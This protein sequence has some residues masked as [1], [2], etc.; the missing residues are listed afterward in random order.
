MSQDNKTCEVTYWGI[1]YTG[2]IV[3]PEVA[4][5]NN[6]KYAVVSI[7]E[8][9]FYN[10]ADLTSAVI[11]S[12]VTSIG[13]NAFAYCNNLTS[14]TVG[15]G[16]TSIGE[17]AFGNCEKLEAVYITDLAA[18]C[19]IDFGV[20]YEE[21]A[22]PLFNAHNLYL[23]GELVTSL[24]IPDGV[25]NINDYAFCYCTSITSVATSNS[26][27]N[28]GMYA[29]YDCTNL[30]SIDI[31]NSVTSI[32]RAAFAECEKLSSVT[33]G[34]GVRD[35]GSGAFSQCENLKAVYITDIEAWCKIN[36]NSETSNPIPYAH[37]LYINGQLATSITIPETITSIN[38]YAFFWCSLTSIDIPNSVTSIGKYAFD[39]CENLSSIVIPNSVTNIGYGA[40]SKCTNLTSIVIP[41]SLTSISERAFNE[42]KSL[43]TVVIPNGV[44]SIGEYAFA[45]CHGL[46]S[47]EIPSSITTIG[48]AAF[49]GCTSLTTVNIHDLKAWCNIDFSWSFGNAYN[50]YLNGELVEELTIPESITEIKVSTFYY[51][52]SL[53]AITIPN[54]VS[55]IGTSAFAHCTNLKT[56]TIPNSVK[57]IGR[58]A[59]YGCTSLTSL[60]MQ[61]SETSANG[62]KNAA[63]NRR[64]A[65]SA[66]AATIG[67]YAFAN[68]TELTTA[69]ISDN[70][71]SIGSNA[72]YNDTKLAAIYMYPATPPTFGSDCFK[73]IASDHIIYVPNGTYSDYTASS[74]GTLNIVGT[75]LTGVD[76]IE[77]SDESVVK[78]YYTVDGKRINAPQRG[79]SIVKYS[80]GTT[81]KVFKK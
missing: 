44:T 20:T 1:K 61:N 15:S 74:I 67:D 48:S 31:S 35:I 52:N 36:F 2:D 7:T 33:M 69:S 77:S 63:R 80:N 26:V 17:Y 8:R 50:L 4:I 62:K 79:L 72:F 53:I 32:G 3:I 21:S 9:A 81:K 29:F 5:Y 70:V 39:A 66:N 14:V 18:W 46:K 30:T 54:T 16:V 11:P 25:T 10:C 57:T 41:S 12:S 78:A 40:F 42:C 60:T 28:I 6:E 23:N 19:S 71:T 75:D 55:A 58:Q 37:D 59:F 34:K 64:L 49:Y 65:P 56:I 76:G 45:F 43:E 47:V 13:K 51:C 22:N 38:N 27:T 73:N 68:C 24:T